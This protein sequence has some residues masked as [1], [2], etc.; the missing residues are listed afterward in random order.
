MPGRTDNP[1]LRVIRAPG[2]NHTAAGVVVPTMTTSRA[3]LPQPAHVRLTI[4]GP[5]ADTVLA[6]AASLAML[7]DATGP[8]TPAPIPGEEGLRCW[9]YAKLP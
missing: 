1:P 9:L 3:H 4:D 7:Y 8:S 6:M 5:D 2:R